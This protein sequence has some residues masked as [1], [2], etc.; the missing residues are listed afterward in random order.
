MFSLT[1][2][3]VVL[4]AAVGYVYAAPIPDNQPYAPDGTIIGAVRFHA[5]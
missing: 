4:S 5:H 2:A 1:K 3:L